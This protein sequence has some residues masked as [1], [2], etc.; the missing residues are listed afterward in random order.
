MSG[1]KLKKAVDLV[2]ESSTDDKKSAEQSAKDILLKVGLMYNRSRMF[3]DRGVIRRTGGLTKE[4]YSRAIKYGD[5]AWKAHG[6]KC[7]LI[8]WDCG[9]G[10]YQEVKRIE[11]K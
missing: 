2:T 3:T 5:R 10:W 6:K 4:H 9:N 8:L 1:E 7:D 11:K